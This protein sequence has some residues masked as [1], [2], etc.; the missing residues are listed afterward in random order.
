MMIF[1]SCILSILHGKEEIG[2]WLFP[3][4]I[5]HLLPILDWKGK[6]KKFGKGSEGLQE[7]R[8]Y[9]HIEN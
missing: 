8:R 4:G 3:N 6:E 7:V 9:S 5:S 2:I 1:L